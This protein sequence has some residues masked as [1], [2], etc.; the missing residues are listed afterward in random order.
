MEGGK[1]GGKIRREKREGEG[2]KEKVRKEMGL[3]LYMNLAGAPG[4]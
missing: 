1:E 3:V 2:R 4:K